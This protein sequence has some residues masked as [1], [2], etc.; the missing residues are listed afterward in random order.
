MDPQHSFGGHSLDRL[1]VDFEVDPSGFGGDIGGGDMGAAPA[2]EPA[3]EPWS[4]SQDDW[5]QFQQ[6]QQQLAETVQTLAAIEAQRAAPYLGGQQGQ[7]GQQQGPPIPDP[8][9][10]PD[11]YH[12]DLRAWGESL[13]A[14][15]RERLETLDRQQGDEQVLDVLHNLEQQH[16]E[17]FA[18]VADRMR[19][20]AKQ[21][22]RE[23]YPQY[24]ARMG[25]NGDAAGEAALEAGYKYAKQFE[26]ELAQ[27]AV[28]RHTNE[29]QTLAGAPRQPGS[30]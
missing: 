7:P 26:S 3:A 6:S 9:E 13:T 21:H 12:D 4:L 25:G 17:F 24:A 19:N 15:F 27:A 18:P 29:I 5:T 2:G 23:V 20:I 1:I 10:R 22:A 16:G 14:P 28:Q 11:T 30:T 8:W